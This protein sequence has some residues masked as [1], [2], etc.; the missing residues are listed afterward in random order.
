[1]V[2]KTAGKGLELKMDVDRQ[3]LQKTGEDLA[4][5][6][7]YLTDEDR[8]L[9]TSADRKV[10][11]TVEGAGVLQGFGSAD[12]KTTENFFDTERTTFDGKV[13]AVIRSKA[14]TGII[15]VTASAEGCESKTVTLQVS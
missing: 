8:I 12:P 1:M 9:Q 14:E 7:I 11:V 10:S 6:I 15:A 5:V 4:Y 3:V 13:L 2:L